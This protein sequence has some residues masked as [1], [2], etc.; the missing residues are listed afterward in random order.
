MAEADL[1]GKG[2]DIAGH[3]GGEETRGLETGGIERA[4]DAGEENRQLHVDVDRAL[5]AFVDE[6]VLRLG[7]R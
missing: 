4:C 5:I 2:R 7:L 3:I 1:I 6:H